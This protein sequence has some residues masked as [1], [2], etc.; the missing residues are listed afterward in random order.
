MPNTP[1]GPDFDPSRWQPLRIATGKVTDAH[2]NPIIDLADPDSYSQQT[3]LTPHW[4]AVRP[5]ALRSGD[6]FRPPPPPK[7]GSPAPYVDALGRHMTNDQAYHAQ[8]D[9]IV[10]ISAN[11]T[12]EQKV[13]AEYWADGPRSETPPG[14]WNA[15]AHGIS[16]RDHH[17]IDDDV[18]LYWALNGALFDASIAAWDAKRAYDCIRPVSA[19]RHK[20]AGQMVVA[21]GGPN[22]GTQLIRGEEWRPYQEPTFVTPAFPEFVSGHSAF[23]AAAAAVLTTFTGSSQFY[24]GETVLH[25]VDRNKDGLSDLLGQHVVP[26]G[27]NRLERSPSAVVVLQWETFQEAADEAGMSRRYGGIHFQDG[28]LWG[29]RIGRNIGAQALALATHY[30]TGK[31]AR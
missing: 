23:S 31:I 19:I 27:G 14:H 28:D 1:G 3:F 7:A 18:K 4:G 20:Y 13:I 29:R 11:L 25:H 26:A 6:Q 9:E 5:F 10:K 21:W 17:T 8:L 16:T 15:L 2:G 30:W 24:D 12:D 22:R